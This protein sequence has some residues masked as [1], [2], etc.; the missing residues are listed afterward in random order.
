MGAECGRGGGRSCEWEALGSGSRMQSGGAGEGQLCAFLSF[1]LCP[2]LHFLLRLR[3]LLRNTCQAGAYD[4]QVSSRLRFHSSIVV[5]LSALGPFPPFSDK[6]FPR[7]K[8]L[9]L[10]TSHLCETPGVRSDSCLIR[11]TTIG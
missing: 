3:F 7:T 8:T 5:F 11:D 4:H 2:W 1:A 6:M 9:P 10:P